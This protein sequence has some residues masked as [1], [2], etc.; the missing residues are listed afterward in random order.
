MKEPLVYIIIL[1][2]NGYK[3]TIE[4]IE[5]LQR[6]KYE[7]YKIVIVDNE[8]TNE[9]VKILKSKYPKIRLFENKENLGFSGGV[10]IGIKWALKNKADY[11]L[12]LNNDT[13][14]DK[15]FLSNL[16][17]T[18][19]GKNM[20]GIVSPKIYY[21]DKPNMIFSMGGFKNYAG[22]YP[23]I[24]HEIKKIDTG[25][26]NKLEER[27]CVIGCCMLIEKNIFKNIGLF[28]DDYFLYV[29]DM[30]FSIR[31][32]NAGYKI[33]VCQKSKIWHKV[34]GSSGGEGNLVK[35][36]YNNRNLILFARKNLTFEKK[37]FYFNLIKG[38]II[39][40]LI[41][42][43]NGMYKNTFA[44]WHGIFDGVLGKK[45]VNLKV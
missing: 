29:E 4:C 25:Q 34:S 43:N 9:S 8:S 3:D 30:D 37:I 26:Y 11:I 27:D 39:E 41:Y 2:W 45:G 5:S 1:N 28:D 13:F 31:V 7:N 16:V 22:L 19:E 44:M 40:T 32:K 36:Y 12:L 17:D 6:I 14:V 23:F 42:L 33:F 38:R 10:N 15:N 21:S 20:V 24:D 18:V 35:E